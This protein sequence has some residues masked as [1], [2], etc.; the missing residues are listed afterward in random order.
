MPP[1]MH[2]YDEQ[3]RK[4]IAIAAKDANDRKILKETGFEKLDVLMDAAR[5]GDQKQLAALLAEG[6]NPNMQRSPDQ[7]TAMHFA[8]IQGHIEIVKQLLDASANPNI[9]D[10]DG[11][12][13][14]SFA[15]SEGEKDILQL[16]LDRGAKIDLANN[17]GLTPLHVAAIQG[18]DEIVKIL[19]KESKA[20][21][22]RDKNGF[23]ALHYAA[24]TE[25]AD[26]VDTLLAAGADAN[27]RSF[28]NELPYNLTHDQVIKDR[29]R[30]Y[31]YL[32]GLPEPSREQLATM[33]EDQRNSYKLSKYESLGKR[34]RPAN[35]QKSR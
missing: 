19:L 12:T 35:S 13:P 32:P 21:D 33:S 25:H 7:E 34:P 20:L 14:L 29:L 18:Q 31:T 26:V 2:E 3:Q 28:Q 9:T 4:A 8:V 16:L 1:K 10:K 15:A 5:H 6:V 11:Y 17:D 24:E 30:T 27:Y 22:A 23:T